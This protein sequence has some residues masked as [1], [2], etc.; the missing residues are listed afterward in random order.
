MTK[1]ETMRDYMNSPHS[2]ELAGLYGVDS[3]S[4]TT[5]SK[6]D[7]A[8]QDSSYLRATK[9]AQL[10]AARHPFLLAIREAAYSHLL[11]FERP[12]ESLEMHEYRALG[13][14]I[15]A[16]LCHPH[17]LYAGLEIAAG[18][19]LTGQQAEWKISNVKR[20]MLAASFNS[21]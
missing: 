17:T 8:V 5:F 21:R 9:I 14:M 12:P 19:L 4:W 2:E 18:C 11:P 1:F 20:D 6:A 10:L 3:A 16:S 13:S 7:V 15:T